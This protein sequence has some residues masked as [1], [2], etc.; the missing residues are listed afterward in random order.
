MT[1]FDAAGMHRILG[2]KDPADASLISMRPSRSPL[3][4]F[5][6]RS[7]VRCGRAACNAASFKRASPILP[8]IASA[9]EIARAAA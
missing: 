2:A 5:R 7:S 4:I 9:R 6:I 1:L 3:N 8:A